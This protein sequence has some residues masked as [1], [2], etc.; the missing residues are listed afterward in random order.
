M[1]RLGLPTPGADAGGLG[2]FAFV[3]GLDRVEA[4]DLIDWFGEGR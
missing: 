4:V 3:A 2:G 1:A